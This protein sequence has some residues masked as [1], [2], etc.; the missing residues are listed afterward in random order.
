MSL[1]DNKAVVRRLYEEVANAKQLDV[2][3][4]IVHSD[5]VDH[6]PFPGMPTKGTEAYRA[7]FGAS[8]AAFPDFHMS[9]DALIAEGDRVAVQGTVSGT[10]QGEF[11]GM[12]P[13]GNSFSVANIEVFE[14]HDGKIT[15][16]W[17][18]ADSASL[19][20]QLGVTPGM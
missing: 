3:D 15:A 8:I 6:D 17:G 5:T 10:H 14:I 4:E 18:I 12:A 20:E 19:M 11:M 7:I 13:T 1:E 16:R 9:I 2:I